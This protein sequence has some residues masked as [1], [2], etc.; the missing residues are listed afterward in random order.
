MP[1]S[2][3][4]CVDRKAYVRSKGDA[5]LMT[6]PSHVLVARGGS[7][8]HRGRDRLWH[9]FSFMALRNSGQLI[10]EFICRAFEV[11]PCVAGPASGINMLAP[12]VEMPGHLQ[13]AGGREAHDQRA[14]RLILHHLGGWNSK[15]RAWAAALGE[16][17]QTPS[18]N[19]SSFW[20]TPKARLANGVRPID[21]VHTCSRS[22]C[23]SLTAL[24]RSPRSRNTVNYNAS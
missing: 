19:S 12:D 13:V 9:I 24:L 14:I 17:R 6:W 5:K 22:K 21:A 20:N 23:A 15:P 1:T 18:P 2:P 8:A 10:G 11:E 16:K 4:T 3:P 7:R